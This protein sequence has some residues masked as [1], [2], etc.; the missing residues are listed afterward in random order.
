MLLSLF[1]SLPIYMFFSGLFGWDDASL[2]E[3]RDAAELVPA[4]FGAVARMAHRVVQLGS[5][6]SPLNNRFPGEWSKK[7]P[8]TPPN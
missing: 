1:G 8:Q 4:P 6:L 3:F 5:S 2:A 7:P